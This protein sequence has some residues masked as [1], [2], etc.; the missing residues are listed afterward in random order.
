MHAHPVPLHRLCGLHVSRFCPEGS[1]DHLFITQ[2]WFLQSIAKSGGYHLT[3][4]HFHSASGLG[5]KSGGRE[6]QRKTLVLTVRLTLSLE[7]ETSSRRSS[8]SC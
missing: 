5:D 4:M 3:V 8:C 7:E 1:L 2:A 6:G